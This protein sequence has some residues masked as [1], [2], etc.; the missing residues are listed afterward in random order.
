M[1]NKGLYWAFCVCLSGFQQ[2]KLCLGSGS[3]SCGL[4]WHRTEACRLNPLTDSGVNIC[5]FSTLLDVHTDMSQSES[6]H[7]FPFSRTRGRVRAKNTQRSHSFKM[8]AVQLDPEK[9]AVCPTA[10]RWDVCMCYWTL[11]LLNLPVLLL[12]VCIFSRCDWTPLTRED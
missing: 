7:I 12:W 10:V 11:V 4:G 5:F 6:T 2:S 1:C 8:R 9:R 3:L